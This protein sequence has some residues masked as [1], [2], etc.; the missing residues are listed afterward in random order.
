MQQLVFLFVGLLL[1]VLLFL[2]ERSQLAHT[3]KFVFWRSVVAL[4][5]FTVILLKSVI[6]KP[7]TANSVITVLLYIPVATY[8]IT[9]AFKSYTVIRK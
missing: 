2:I 4:V 1:A 9:K 3:H 7:I 5:I 6:F 8:L